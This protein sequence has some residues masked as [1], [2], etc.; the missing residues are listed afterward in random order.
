[1]RA[2]NDSI[3]LKYSAEQI[4][5]GN[6]AEAEKLKRRALWPG[7]YA[8]NLDNW[9]DYFSISQLIII[10][11]DRLRNE[12]HFVL[13]EL[14]EKFQMHQIDGLQ[15]RLQYSKEKGFYCIVQDEKATNSTTNITTKKMHCL[16][17]SK[18]RQYKPISMKLRRY[19]EAYFK[20]ANKSL[21]EWLQ[22]YQFPV[23]YFLL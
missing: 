5:M 17:S 15:N 16:G 13:H 20:G 7:H 18:G 21:L 9:L 23:P 3:A 19:L 10:D 2:H 1:M 8:K 6:I 11:G 4:F 14:F 22:K 12:P